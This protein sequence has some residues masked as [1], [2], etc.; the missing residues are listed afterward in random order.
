MKKNLYIIINIFY[1]EKYYYLWIYEM[2]L[3]F[4]FSFQRIFIKLKNKRKKNVY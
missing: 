2:N 3:I 4:K 1:N